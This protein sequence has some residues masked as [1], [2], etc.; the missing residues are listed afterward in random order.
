[1]NIEEQEDEDDEIA[2]SIIDEVG[3]SEPKNSSSGS[4]IKESLH[5]AD[6]TSQ[7]LTNV[8][9]GIGSE[10]AIRI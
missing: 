9:R 4:Q 7:Q 5:P 8:R 10:E 2:E 6:S 1:M 3:E